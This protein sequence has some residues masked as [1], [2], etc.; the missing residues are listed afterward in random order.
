MLVI[1]TTELQLKQTQYIL[2]YLGIKDW[3]FYYKSKTDDL[4]SAKFDKVALSRSLP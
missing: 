1:K 3:E 4:I 2:R